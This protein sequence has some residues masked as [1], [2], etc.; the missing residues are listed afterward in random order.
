MELKILSSSEWLQISEAA[1]L[2]CFNEVRPSGMERI[3]YALVVEKDGIPLGYATI[4][5]T[6]SESVYL[7]HGGALPSAIGTTTSFSCYLLVVNYLM[8]NYQ[9]ISTLI[10]NTN[11]PMLKFAMKAGLRIVGI[12]NIRN[13]ILLE[14]FWERP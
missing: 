5:E 7:Q 2:V 12:R 13:S 10:E 4:R 14:N 3:D 6:D 8:E 9:R 1:H 11:T